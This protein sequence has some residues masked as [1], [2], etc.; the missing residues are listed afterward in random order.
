MA[1]PLVSKGH[2]DE[3]DLIIG[4]FNKLSKP[5]VFNENTSLALLIAKRNQALN[6]IEDRN[7]KATQFDAAIGTMNNS[8]KELSKMQSSFLLQVGDFYGKNSDEYV[9][10]G[11]VRQSDAIERAKLTR[12]EKLKADVEQKKKE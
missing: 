11:G 6:A 10:A 7:A 5:L 3:V 8:D 2:I 4:R 9:W 12:Q 1:T